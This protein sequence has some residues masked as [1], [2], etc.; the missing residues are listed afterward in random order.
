MTYPLERAS[1]PFYN[2]VR[3]LP[4]DYCRTY[5]AILRQTSRPVILHRLGEAFD[6]SLT[7]YLS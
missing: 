2:L 3:W 5:G 6:P 7:G 1:A 4:D